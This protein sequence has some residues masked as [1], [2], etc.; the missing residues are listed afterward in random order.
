MPQL[1]PRTMSLRAARAWILATVLGMPTIASADIIT[2][3]RAF[4][5]SSR[6][7]VSGSGMADALFFEWFDASLGTLDR[8]DVTI[9]AS[10][11]MQLFLPTSFIPTPSG[12]IPVPYLYNIRTSL[13]FDG[14][15]SDFLTVPQVMVTGE[16]PGGTGH[17]PLVASAGITHEFSYTATSDLVGF[18][19]V[20][21]TH[22][23]LSA[24]LGV[25]TAVPP[26]LSSG[27]RDDF[28]APVGGVPLIVVPI[29]RT[30]PPSFAGALL[31]GTFNGTLT[32]RGRMTIT[33]DFT[34]A[35]PP[36]SV[37]ESGTSMLVVGGL[38]ALIA[39]RSLRI[40]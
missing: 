16:A 14:P 12:P 26:V 9:D 28:V 29:L 5:L 27:E 34:P 40:A 33:Y 37:P 7:T 35:P 4:E 8:V 39:R 19:V 15:A 22:S 30:S 24:S 36:A 25:V 32:A 6:V 31:P 2:Q 10:L 17:T 21:S 3:V 20:A 18:A 38:L 1:T 23:P 13:D 11:L